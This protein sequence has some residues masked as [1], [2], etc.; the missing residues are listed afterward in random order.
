MI[1]GDAKNKK[2]ISTYG[3]PKNVYFLTQYF[4]PDVAST[5]QLLTELAEDLYDYGFKVKVFTAQPSYEGFKKCPRREVY[6]GI[7]I[8]RVW[9][10]HF[11]KNNV[12]GKVVDMV[13]F[14][15]SL[16]LRMFF[17]RYKRNEIFLIVTNPPFLP[18]AGWLLK[19]IRKKHYICLIHDVYPDLAVKLGYLSSGSIVTKLWDALNKIVLNNS[20]KVIV[21][22]EYMKK[23]VEGKLDR[24][25]QDKNK[26]V[27]IHNWA[28]ES[29]IYPIPKSS[30]WFVKG[31]KLEGKFVVLYSGNLGL[32][33]PIE[34][35]I[36]VAEALKNRNILFLFIGNGGKKP[37]LKEMVK[38]KKLKNV[39]FLPYQSKDMLAYSLSSGDVAIVTMEKGIEGLSVPSKLY[40]YL[41][42]GRP[43]LA[44]VKENSDVGIIVK[45]AQCGFVCD[46]ED[47]EEISKK[48]MYLVDHPEVKTMF[49]ENARE[50]FELHFARSIAAKQYVYL[51]NSIWKDLYEKHNY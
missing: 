31:Q 5:G 47:I 18:I 32:S 25:S 50:Y 27:V 38:E 41:A 26:I 20:D 10:T 16:S 29:K 30:N 9:C 46:P 17:S 2:E 7:N 14:V 36:Y 4:Y 12:L 51:L 37:I 34:A 3:N 13:S 1:S 19:K 39:K 21:L 40:S 42:A 48:I 49:S 43:I 24:L 23:I 33:H 35:I 6:N 22:G 11:P 44:L 28:D 15:L 45:K 8:I